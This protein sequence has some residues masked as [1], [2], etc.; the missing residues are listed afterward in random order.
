MAIS[1]L[2]S[3][4]FF[5]FIIFVDGQCLDHQKKLLLDLKIELVFNSTL[6]RNLVTW[7]LTHDCCKWGGVECDGFGRVVSLDLTSE[8][9]S[10]RMGG[11]STLFRLTYLSELD[12]SSND[13][14]KSEIPNQFHRLT[15]LRDL[16]LSGCGFIGSIPPTVSNLTNLVYLDLSRNSLTG[17]L[18]SFHL[19]SQ[20]K[21]IDLRDNHITGSL[22]YLDF[23]SLTNLSSILLDQNSLNGSIPHHLFLLP[24]LRMLILSNNQFIGQI[25]EFPVVNDLQWMDLSNNRI[26]GPI[27]ISFFRFQNISFLWLSDNLFDGTFQLRNIQSLSKLTHLSLSYNK[28]SIDTT[29][30]S[31]NSDRFPQF[32]TLLL[33]FCNLYEFPYLENQSSLA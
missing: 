12:L 9:I 6:S 26:H 8:G 20:L 3:V 17:S 33:A 15:N 21:T 13:F 25:E 24:S 2:L 18:P 31:S 16:D 19:C 29:N 30:L 1:S 32:D 5:F 28:L 10:G 27:P 7:N 23:G 4:F 14:T 22:S 11:T